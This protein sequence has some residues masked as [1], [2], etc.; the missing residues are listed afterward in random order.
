MGPEDKDVLYW[1][2]V[3]EYDLEVAQGMLDK[4]FYL[5]VGFMC[6]Q[7]IEKTL[8]A[9]FVEK[10]HDVPPYSHNLNMLMEKCGIGSDA[11]ED[12]LDFIDRLSPLNIQARYPAY[13]DDIKSLIKQDYAKIILHETRKYQLWLAKRIDTSKT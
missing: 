3:A 5:Y 1:L 6:H 9:V 2:Q 10:N 12:F 4:G 11:P 8:K 7:C 13:K